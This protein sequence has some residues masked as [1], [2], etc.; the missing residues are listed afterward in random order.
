MLTLTHL[1]KLHKE[2]MFTK[3]DG[4]ILS[5]RKAMNIVTSNIKYDSD[6]NA[7]GTKSDEEILNNLNNTLSDSEKQE[8]IDL[9]K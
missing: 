3:R 9:L 8:V 7:I 1:N 5:W 6:G 2:S 4:G